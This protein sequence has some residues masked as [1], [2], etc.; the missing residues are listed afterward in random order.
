M[1]MVVQPIQGWGNTCWDFSQGSRAPLT[2]T[3]TAG[4]SDGTP[5]EFGGKA[6]GDAE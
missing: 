3:A 1:A 6:G 2:R 4:L 5:L